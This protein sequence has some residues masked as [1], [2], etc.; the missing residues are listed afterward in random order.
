MSLHF[1]E[2]SSRIEAAGG[3]SQC[4]CEWCGR[5]SVTRKPRRD[6]E[7]GLTVS[8]SRTVANAWVFGAGGGEIGVFTQSTW[9][10][11]GHGLSIIG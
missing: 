1:H 10:I 3:L 7:R 4:I 6:R 5:A 8:V 2:M 9:L 11:F